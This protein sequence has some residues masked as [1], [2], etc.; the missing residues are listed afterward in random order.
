MLIDLEKWVLGL[1]F[2]DGVN[3]KTMKRIDLLIQLLTNIYELL[4]LHLGAPC[5]CFA[6][7]KET[8]VDNG[9][10]SIVQILKSIDKQVH[11]SNELSIDHHNAKE[12]ERF[13]DSADIY[14]RFKFGRTKLYNLKRKGILKAYKLG[15][16]DYFLESE[17][18]QAL[19]NQDKK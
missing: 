14:Q 1:S 12:Q 10:R 5:N 18:L 9:D 4:K 8:Q 2:G 17:V 15:G 19:M 11:L 3:P 6:A 16:K 7:D 13:L